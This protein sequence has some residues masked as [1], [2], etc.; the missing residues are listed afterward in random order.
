MRDS[1]VAAG[2][3]IIGAGGWWATVSLIHTV[4]PADIL[5][6]CIMFCDEDTPARA[7]DMGSRMVSAVGKRRYDKMS[8]QDYTTPASEQEMRQHGARMAL[9]V[10]NTSQY[11]MLLDA[12]DLGEMTQF[13]T[14]N[15]VS[16]TLS[17]GTHVDP[18]HQLVILGALLEVSEKLHGL[19]DEAKD[20]D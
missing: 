19:T 2:L 1:L 5:E 11:M 3:L 14:D 18:G 10:G 6:T 4:V 13:V 8:D 15:P 16:M 17:D 7:N 12:M 20:G 9:V